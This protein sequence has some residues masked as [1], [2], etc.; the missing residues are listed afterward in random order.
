MTERASTDPSARDLTL[1]VY[2]RLMAAYGPQG[3]WPGAEEP[4]EVCIGA[5]LAQNTAWTN[6]ERAL[7]RLKEAGVMSTAALAAL[8]AEELTE[9]LRP[10]GTFRSKSLTVQAFVAHLGERYGGDLARMLARP[11]DSLREEL[12]G[13]RGIG[14]ETA[15][16]ILLYAAGHPSFVVD[17]YT[18]RILNR[19]GVHLERDSYEAWRTFFMERLPTDVTL[20]NEY[21]ALLDRLGSRV[22]LKRAP[23]C[24]EC[25][26][27]QICATGLEH[28]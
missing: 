5:I 24:Y 11:M 19:I 20:F 17:A 1:E 23:R 9:L 8:P 28:S 27:Q 25:P 7:A 16:D 10:S 21:H 13:I 18:R 4:L 6:A 26:L 3:W 15:D 12:L 14:P 2:R 22:C